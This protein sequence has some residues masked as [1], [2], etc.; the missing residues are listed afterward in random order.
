MNPLT[1]AEEQVIVRKGTER[2]FTGE[3]NDFFAEG[4][5][6][7]RR[8]EAPL[9]RSSA[10]FHSDCGWPS[11]DQEVPGAVKRLPELKQYFDVSFEY[12]NSLKPNSTKTL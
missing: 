12:V 3:Y 2:P 4:T 9:Y 10:K 8:C 5:Y 7:C 11:F 6:V 1:P